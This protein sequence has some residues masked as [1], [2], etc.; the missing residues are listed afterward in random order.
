MAEIESPD[1][2]YRQR[3]SNYKKA[4]SKLSRAVKSI[5]AKIETNKKPQAVDELLRD[6]LIH[7]KFFSFILSIQQNR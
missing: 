1:T 5:Q 2:R 3:F 4:L 6:G 7:Q